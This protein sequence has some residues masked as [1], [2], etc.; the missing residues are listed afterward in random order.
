MNACKLARLLVSAAAGALLLAPAPAGAAPTGIHKIQHVIVVMQENRSFDSYFGTYPG[1]DGI[2]AGVCISEPEGGPCVAPYHDAESANQGGPHGSKAA[3]TDIDSG[4][5]DGFLQAL[6]VARR[7]CASGTDAECGCSSR[8]RCL[9]VMGYHD[10]RE[11]P[12]YWRYAQN[13]VL[14][15]NMFQSAA[16]W[17]L[18]EHLF[19]VSGWSAACPNGD[20][21]PLDCTSAL[22][23]PKPRAGLERPWTDITWLLHRAGV[24]WRYYIFEGGEPD[25]EDDE[26][27][28]CR[29]AKQAVN[30][31][32][33]WNLLPDFTDVREDGQLEDIQSIHSLFSA[34]QAPGSCELPNVAWVVPNSKV[35]EHPPATTEAGQAYVTTL[36]NTVMRSPCWGS[37]AIFVSWDDWG[38]FYDHVAPP[39]VDA[40]G[41]GLRVPGLV[42]SPYARAGFVDNHLLSHDSYLRFIEDDF[43]EGARLNPATD[44]RPDGRPD[45]REELAG[46]GSLA[47]DFDFDQAPRPPM[48]LA[49]HPAAGPASLPPGSQQPPALEDAPPSGVGRTSV[50]LNATVNPD[51]ANIEECVFEYGTSA[52]YGQSVP[53]AWMPEAGSSPVPVSAAIGG[54][55]PLTTYHFRAVATGAGGTSYGPDLQFETASSPPLVETLRAGGIEQASAQLNATVDPEG[56]EVTGCT[57]EYGLDTGYGSSVPC[58]TAP[59]GGRSPVPVS[60]E[61]AGLSPRSVYHYRIVATNGAGTTYGPDETLTTLPNP[62]AARTLGASAVTSDGAQLEG[63]V[64]PEGG[65]VTECR[66]EYGPSSSYGNSAPCAPAPGSGT[67]PVAVAGTVVNLSGR[68]L[69]HYRLVATNAGGTTDGEDETLL[70]LPDPPG[71]ETAAATKVEP[72]SARLNGQVNPGGAEVTA[73]T[74]E[75]GT[76]PMLGASVPCPTLPGAGTKPV[77]VGVTVRRL[78]P[79]TIYWFRLSAADAGGTAYGRE[80]PFTTLE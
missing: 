42:I 12:N 6:S 34:A 31:T 27:L 69:Y 54:L 7:K 26:A 61:A 53:C 59:G 57:F 68:T 40:D 39:S 77:K 47:E 22:E 9:D 33:I 25:C 46:L 13:Y 49:S 28:T 18:P 58:T 45:V 70:T 8:A 32:G 76:T 21:N 4:R 30:T 16:S 66:F 19:L 24:S 44:G 37:T 60:A 35:S 62:P 80:L 63:Q 56:S 48:L 50:T 5:M 52:S 78:A 15:D 73:C 1:A 29:P 43:L 41:L 23:P 14:Q 11:I 75:Y 79:A 51:R 36:V 74:F 55:A 64:D 10:A 17:S 71:V 72:R 65:E 3:R 38:G 20:P 67:S 2:P